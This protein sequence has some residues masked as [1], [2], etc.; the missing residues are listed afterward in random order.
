[1]NIV[2]E[3]V[4]LVSRRWTHHAN[5]SG[6]DRLSKFI[7]TP[8]T[9]KPVPDFLLPDRIYWQLTR[10]ITTYDRTS[11]ALEISTLRHMAM[12]KGCLYHF[13]YGESAYK[14]LGKLNGWRDHRLVVTYHKP[15]QN[16]AENVRNF[17][18]VKK[19]SAVI[20]VGRNQL[21]MFNGILPEERMF[22]VPHP[23]ETTFFLPPSDFWERENNLCLFVGSHLRDFQT[24]RSV[25]ENAWILAPKVKFALV[26]HP[27][28][29]SMFNGVVGNYTIYSHLDENDLLDLYRTAALLIMPIED[30]TANNSVLEAMSCGLPM[31]VADVGAIKDYV[32]EGCAQFVPP[33]EPHE[34][35][36]AILF[37]LDSNTKRKQMAKCAREKALDYDWR[38]IAEQLQSIYLQILDDR[39]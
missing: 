16:F 7:G 20:V 6:Y 30:T 31:V 39:R 23:V 1:M 18:H 5:H 15:P 19:L 10:E 33:F 3:K 35:L 2:Q 29:L 25:I 24:L 14:F 4:F 11:L 27:R 26:V 21:S 36:D 32:S 17:E 22:F 38:E 8:L 13:L 9:S 28:Q 12:N 37:L 34:M